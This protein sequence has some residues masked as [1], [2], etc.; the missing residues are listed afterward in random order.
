MALEMKAAPFQFLILATVEPDGV[1][2][3]DITA[4]IVKNEV[5]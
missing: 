1:Y 2:G 3:K 4:A 5:Y